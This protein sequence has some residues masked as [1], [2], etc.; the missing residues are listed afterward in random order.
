MLKFYLV[1][2]LIYYLVSILIYFI[3]LVNAC[4]VL[5]KSL[6][7]NGWIKRG[8]GADHPNLIRLATSCIPIYRL[9]IIVGLFYFSVTSKEEYENE[10]KYR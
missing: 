5:S 9:M 3:I 2:I 6:E 4:V 7:E 8:E 10:K 1:S